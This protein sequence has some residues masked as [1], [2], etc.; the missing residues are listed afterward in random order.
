MS[1]SEGEI[2]FALELFSGLGDVTLRRMF[3]GLC[4]YRD[5]TVFALLLSDGTLFLKGA[6]RFR[7]RIEAEGWERWVHTRKTGKAVAMPYWRLPE[8]ALEDPD[9]A[10]TLARAALDCL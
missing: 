8:A 7:D 1:V 6:G 10:C 5:G 3:G 4:L 9:E 2:A